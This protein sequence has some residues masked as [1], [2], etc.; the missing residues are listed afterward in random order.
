MTKPDSNPTFLGFSSQR[1]LLISSLGWLGGLSLLSTGIAYAQTS[2]TETSSPAVDSSAVPS[3]QELFQPLVEEAPTKPTLA[4]PAAPEEFS[5]LPQPAAPTAIEPVSPEQNRPVDAIGNSPAPNNAALSPNLVDNAKPAFGQSGAAGSYIDPTPYAL[6]ATHPDVIF[7]ERSTGCQ[8]VL[9]PGQTVPNS[10]CPAPAVTTAYSSGSG[11]EGYAGSTGSYGGSYSGSITLPSIQN[12]YN[13]TVRPPAQISNGNISLMFPLTIPA[14]I[15]SAFGWRIHP[16]AGESRFHSGTDIGAPQGTPVVA[17][18]GGKVQIADLMGGYG[19]AVVLRHDNDTEETLYG[20]MSEVFVKPGDVVKQG[21]VIGRVGSTGYSTGP[22]L[23]FEFHK[24]TPQG[25]V[26]LDPGQA[27]EYS[28]AQLIEGI[29]PGQAN[30]KS[31]FASISWKSL[32]KA[33][34]MAEAKPQ[35]TAALGQLKPQIKPGVA[36]SNQPK[37][38]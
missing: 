5:P 18:F 3:A 22:H 38:D 4:A 16:I 30:S 33:L 24:L 29:K 20:H 2:S 35:S 15:T 28:L 7:S 31:L 19:L 6:G 36:L 25:W 1:S 10:I 26:V 14:V 23:H 27:L 13:L 11:A 9:Q 21:D 32:Q 34:E 37:V 8:T 12:F 17:A